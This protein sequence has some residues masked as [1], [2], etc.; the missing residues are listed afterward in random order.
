MLKRIPQI[1]IPVHIAIHVAIWAVWFLVIASEPQN[2]Y[3]RMIPF[4]AAYAAGAFQLLWVFIDMCYRFVQGEYAHAIKL[5]AL[6]IVFCASCIAALLFG[7]MALLTMA[8]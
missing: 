3:V 7:F 6:F 8:D 2:F 4:F 1:T 5:L